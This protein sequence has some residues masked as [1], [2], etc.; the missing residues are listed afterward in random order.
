LEREWDE[1]DG[2][3]EMLDAPFFYAAGN[4]DY[5]NQ[6][7]ADVWAERY[8]PSYYSFVYKEVLFVVLNSAL[9]DREGVEGHGQRR[10]DWGAEQEAQLAWLENTLAANADVR[11]TFLLMH[12]PYWRKGW[13]RNDDT[14]ETPAV[15]PWP[16]YKDNVPEWERVEAMLADRDYTAFAGHMHTY[17]YDVDVSGPHTHEK[18][19]LATTGG[20][21]EMRGVSYGEFDHFVWITMTE[22]GPVMANVLLDG[23]I[24]KDRKMP[25]RR[26]YWAPAAPTEMP[27]GEGSN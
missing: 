18:I 7:M 25:D 19:A 26:P 15:G 23:V 24:S 27:A 21:S 5:S 17:E 16:R 9:F 11:W 8:G 4:H 1:L 2:F 20:I 6:V 3:V 22:S 13:I 12:R 10:G 14:E